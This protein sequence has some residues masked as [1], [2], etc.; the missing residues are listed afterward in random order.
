[1]AYSD[2]AEHGNEESESAMIPA[3]VF[4]A[5]L[6]A[7][8][9]PSPA[10]PGFRTSPWFDEQV[11]EEGVAE[12]VRALAD[13]PANFRPGRPTRLVIYATPNGTTIEQTRG[14]AAAP[15]L[16]WHFDIQHVAAQV[17]R[18]REVS[19]EEN[20]VLACV[21]AD[22]LSW[23]AWKRRY[24]DGPARVRKVVEALRGW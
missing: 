11:R 19:P 5:L 1:S 17:R 21:E 8:A 24:T 13:A 23:P 10:L 6:A 20:F 2:D 3:A 14:C 18:L 7:G 12:G 15:G 4:A 16:D 9:S 22:G